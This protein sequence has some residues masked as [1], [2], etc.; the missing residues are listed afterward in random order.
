MLLSLARDQP[1]VFLFFPTRF[2]I[3]VAAI[4]KIKVTNDPTICA[5]SLVLRSAEPLSSPFG[6]EHLS[7]L[8]REPSPS[9]AVGWAFSP[10]PVLPIARYAKNQCSDRRLL[11]IPR[12]GGTCNASRKAVVAC[13]RNS[14]RRSAVER[15]QMSSAIQLVGHSAS[16]WTAPGTLVCSG[17]DRAATISSAL[18]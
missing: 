11:R 6:I 13:L 8:A 4:P 16:T 10:I 1:I 2:S 7:C 18:P 9:K 15:P 14:P 3:R 12:K 17:R 5:L